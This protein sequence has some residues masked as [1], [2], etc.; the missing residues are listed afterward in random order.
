MANH[1]LLTV[2][3]EAVKKWWETL[4]PAPTS[5]RARPVTA[6]VEPKGRGTC[7]WHLYVA[8]K[9]DWKRGSY[10]DNSAELQAT[11]KIDTIASR[12]AG[13]IYREG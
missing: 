6:H 4:D 13:T 2:F 10:K 12:G 3:D 11:R 7:G 5:N 8:E 9:N 1:H